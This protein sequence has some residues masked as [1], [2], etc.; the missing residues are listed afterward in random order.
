[1]NATKIYLKIVGDC[2]TRVNVDFINSTRKSR[3]FLN[4]EIVFELEK[5]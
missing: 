3:N 2:R 5:L 4:F 1:V